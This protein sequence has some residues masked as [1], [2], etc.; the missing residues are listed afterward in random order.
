M[1]KRHI[2][3]QYLGIYVD[4]FDLKKPTHCVP[5]A[6]NFCSFTFKIL[7]LLENLLFRNKEIRNSL[8]QVEKQFALNRSHS[9]LYTQ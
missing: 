8:F 4:I 5:K 1:T 7:A 3:I 2:R 6:K 9:S